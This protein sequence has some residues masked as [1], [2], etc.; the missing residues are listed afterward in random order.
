[1][2]TGIIEA[3]AKVLS[4]TK[5]VLRVERP[6]FF[7]DIKEGSSVAISGIC[8]T[9]TSLTKKEMSFDVIEETFSKTKAASWK[10]GDVVN[11]ERAMRADA[12]FDGHV[13]QGHVE[14]IAVV[15]N[16]GTTL[17]V[18]LPSAFLSFIIPKGSITVDGVALTIASVKKNQCTLA[19]IPETLK[20]T[21]LG[22]LKKGDKVNIETDIFL[23]A[24]YHWTQK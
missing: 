13:V 21:T 12:R 20:R 6:S 4:Q 14:C 18:E 23:K 1:M 5:G 7:T 9:V 19:L 3:T 2:F 16:E 10:P 22:S 15:V 17:A 11:L 8:L 24:L